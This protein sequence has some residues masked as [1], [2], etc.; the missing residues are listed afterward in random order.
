MKN[1]ILVAV[2]VLLAITVI[3]IDGKYK[4]GDI[5]VFPKKCFMKGARPVYKHYAIYVGPSSEI[6]IG[7]GDNDI[8][9]R[10]GE[11][12]LKTDCRFDKLETTRGKWKERVDNYLDGIPEMKNATNE[13]D[14]IKRINLTIQNCREYGVF[15]NNCEHL[16]T[17]VRYGLKIS[18]QRGTLAKFLFRIPSKVRKILGGIKKD[19]AKEMSCES[20]H[21]T[22]DRKGNFFSRMIKKIKS[23]G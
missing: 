18:L 1:P 15:G 22:T 13:E 9:H 5:I 6:D 12:T 3:Q 11:Y 2:I 16:A 21:G 17:Y 20:V 8:F 7:Q 4:F 19:E 14:I 10:T 23:L